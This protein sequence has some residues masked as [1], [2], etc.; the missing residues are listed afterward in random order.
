MSTKIARTVSATVIAAG[1]VASG[2]AVNASQADT[3]VELHRIDHSL[4]VW[5][6]TPCEY[7]DS[8]DCYWDAGTSGNGVGDSFYAVR[9]EPGVVCIR[10]WDVPADN[11]CTED[12]YPI[13]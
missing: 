10:Y 1:L 4:P 8:S 5:M 9:T 7:E 3:T 11:F 13:D 6:T 2:F 12:A